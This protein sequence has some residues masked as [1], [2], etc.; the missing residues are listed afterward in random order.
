MM[1]SIEMDIN[2][3]TESGWMGGWIVD[4]VDGINQLAI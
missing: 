3:W 1:M 4:V 2:L